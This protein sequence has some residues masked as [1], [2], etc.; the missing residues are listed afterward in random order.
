MLKRQYIVTVGWERCLVFYEDATSDK[1]PV[2]PCRIVPHKRLAQQQQAVAHQGHSSDILTAAMQAGKCINVA[3]T[4]CQPPC[5]LLSI[6][7]SRHQHMLSSCTTTL[8]RCSHGRAASQSMA[9]RCRQLESS[10]LTH[11]QRLLHIVPLGTICGHHL[12]LTPASSPEFSA[13]SVLA[14]SVNITRGQMQPEAQQLK[15]CRATI[16]W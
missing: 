1:R 8:W 6:A 10:P 11:L 16:P 2:A 5:R 3:S 12:C 9:K 15:Q 14:V 4:P 7:C 13:T